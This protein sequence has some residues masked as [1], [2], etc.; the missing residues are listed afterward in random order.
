MYMIARFAALQYITRYGRYIPV[1]QGVDMGGTYQ[2]VGTPHRIV[3][4]YISTYLTDDRSIHWYGPVRRTMHDTASCCILF[5]D[6]IVLVDE[7]L[8]I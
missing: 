6:D 8:I 3:C 1:Q 4:Q 7:I 5:V 2:F